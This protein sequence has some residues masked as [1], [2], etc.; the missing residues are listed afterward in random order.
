MPV[1]L[2][3]AAFPAFEGGVG[4]LGALALG[5]LGFG[6]RRG[7]GEGKKTPAT[8]VASCRSRAGA[9]RIT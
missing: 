2:R 3:I 1:A 6:R 8:I 7:R 9:F 5:L 4:A